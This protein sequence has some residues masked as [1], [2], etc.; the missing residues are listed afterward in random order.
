MIELK[1]LK[2]LLDINNYNKYRI[3]IS[4]DINN[5]E[6]NTLYSVLDTMMGSYERTITAEEFKMTAIARDDSLLFLIDQMNALPI[7]KEVVAD[8]VKDMMHRSFA[9]QHALLAIEVSQ[10]KKPMIDLIDSLT[11]VED[12]KD[13][14]DIEFVSDDAEEIYGSGEERSGG[15]QFRLES[16]RKSLGGLHRGDFG[17]IFAR[18]ESGKTTFLAS[19]V[20]HFAAQVTQPILWFNNEERSEKVKSR[21]HSAALGL[22]KESIMKDTVGCVAKYM[23]ITKG[24]IKL[25]DQSGEKLHKKWVERI[26]KELNPSLIVF[27]QLDKITGFG[28]EDREDLKL[29]AAYIW[30][31]G[32]A[33]QYCPIIG[34]SQ[35]DVSG[36]GKQWLH[37]DNVANAKTAKQAEADYIIGI[38]KSH[39]L[40]LEHIRY[41]HLSKNKLTGNHA[42][43]EVIIDAPTARYEDI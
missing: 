13:V 28:K 8:V 37:M 4:I 7:A 3:F 17:F 12:K 40:G 38:G 31:R 22:T 23:D 10:G 9:H 1:I 34:V 25:I 5:K 27:D 35:A 26:V 19:E 6:L 32:L 30:A 11:K 29:G 14:E 15:L 39:K 18:P 43:M 36:E 21:L 42:K 16:L 41:L 33:K 2:Y 20:T 24:N